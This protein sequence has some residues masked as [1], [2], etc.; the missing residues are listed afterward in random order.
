V[1]FPA[2]TNISLFLPITVAGYFGID[3]FSL[4]GSLDRQ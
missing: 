1:L 4:Y 2:V 3:W